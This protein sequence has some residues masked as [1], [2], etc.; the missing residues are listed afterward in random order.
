MSS[1]PTLTQ[2]CPIATVAS[3]AAAND[4]E[5]ETMMKMLTGF[6]LMATFWIGAP[7]VVQAQSADGAIS[8]V[9]Q[10]FEGM[11]T[12]NADMVRAVFADDARF[13]VLD[14]RSGPTQVRSQ[15]VDGWINAIG[16]S[17]G[18]WNEQIYDVEVKADGTMASVWAPYTFYLDGAISHCGIN[19]I[20]LLHD[21]D[22]WKVTQISDT[23]RSA[24]CPDPLGRG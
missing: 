12:A 23:R 14:G 3:T 6:L 11:R 13:A 20:E 2:A 18:S 17:A 10:M 4:R 15:A 19:S 1:P 9:E 7:S 22:G 24:D 16:G 21:A 5:D 8:A